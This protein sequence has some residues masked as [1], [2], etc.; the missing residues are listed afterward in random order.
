MFST[1]LDEGIPLPVVD[2]MCNWYSK[3]F[4]AVLWNS[5]LSILFSVSSGVHHGSSL[6]P[7]L[8]NLYIYVI[9]ISLKSRDCGCYICDKFFGCF[10]YADD[11][12][13][14]AT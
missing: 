5:C 11:V 14:L 4:A 10:L 3:L 1:L 9:I 2:V 6:S 7:A 8:F 13:I 12:I